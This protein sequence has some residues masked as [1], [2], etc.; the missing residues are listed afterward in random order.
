MA[1]TSGPEI[2]FL[3]LNAEQDQLRCKKDTYNSGTESLL[4][5]NQGNENGIGIIDRQPVTKIA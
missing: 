1:L 4:A 2:L 3:G 5:R